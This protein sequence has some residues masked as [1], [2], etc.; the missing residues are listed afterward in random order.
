MS[1]SAVLSMNVG[2]LNGLRLDLKARLEKCN[3]DLPILP[4][5]ASQVLG[6]TADERSDAAR[7]A[8][9]IHSDQALASH[10]LRIANSAAL[11]GNSTIVSLQHAVARLGLELLAGVALAVSVRSGV[12]R[13]PG[14]EEETRSL[15]RH[16][17]AS[18]LYAKEIARRRRHNVETAFLCGLLH[19]IGK[20]VVLKAAVEVAK[21]TGADVGKA[22]IISSTLGS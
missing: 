9:L 13:I 17:L 8:A 2:E 15:W 19:E 4:H 21:K 18:G 7:L 12:Y 3:L 14:F 6:M 5:V 10:V 16:A 1:E 22:G 11:G 20:P